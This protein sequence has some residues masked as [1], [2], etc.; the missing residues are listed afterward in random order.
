MTRILADLPDEDIKWLDQL[1][2]DQ[3]K[4]RAAVLRDAV[5]AYRPQGPLDWIEAGFGAWARHG[6]A[7]AHR[8]YDRNRRA[9]WT[10]PGADPHEEV[11]R[12]SPDYFPGEHG[13][14]PV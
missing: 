2:A 8:D 14:S 3:G 13:R 7:I 5:A 4:S 1:A 12:A 10:R 11:R 6:V 9:E